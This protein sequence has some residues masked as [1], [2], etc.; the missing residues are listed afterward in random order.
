MGLFSRSKKTGGG[1]ASCN[2]CGTNFQTLRSGMY[3]D[4]SVVGETIL[5]M[6]KGCDS[7]GVPVCFECAAAAAD[8]KGRKGHCLC[9]RCGANLDS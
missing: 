2:Y 8:K 3:S 5:R 7:C 4:M 6:R 9:P 1:L